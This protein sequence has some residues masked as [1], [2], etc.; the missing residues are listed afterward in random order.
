MCETF[1]TVKTLLP[2]KPQRQCIHLAERS[3]RFKCNNYSKLNRAFFITILALLTLLE[4]HPRSSIA[5]SIKSNLFV[6]HTSFKSPP[7]VYS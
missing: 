3:L 5:L 1:A 4:T 2:L 7:P 6:E